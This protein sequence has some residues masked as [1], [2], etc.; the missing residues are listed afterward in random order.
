[1]AKGSRLY[2]EF[3]DAVRDN[4]EADWQE[5]AILKAFNNLYENRVNA[6]VGLRKTYEKQ[7]MLAKD[8][9][10]PISEGQCLCKV[11]VVNKVLD[12]LMRG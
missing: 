6:I 2:K 1:M 8:R 5:E 12:I 10:L 9:N 7:S 4:T 11:E 3:L